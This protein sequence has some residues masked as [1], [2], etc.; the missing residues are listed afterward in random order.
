M[1]DLRIDVADLLTHPGSRRPV[2]RVACVEGLA[3]RAARVEEPVALDL[4]LERV[5][6]GIVA[7]GTVRA[8]WSGECGVCLRPLTCDLEIEVGELYEPHPV[9]GDTY[10]LLG[11]QIDL[12][13]LVLDSVLLELPIAP[14][15]ASTG[16]EPCLP[17]TVITPDDAPLD[18]AP[19]D[20]RWAV[21]SELEL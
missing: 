5:S 15:C 4:L 20:A 8:H 1:S 6:D 11:Y 2:S 13:Q 14:T 16:A 10:P 19:A 3:G 9:E 12:E 18:D 17:V 7:R 21:L